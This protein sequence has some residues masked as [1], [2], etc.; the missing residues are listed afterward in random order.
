MTHPR[1]PLALVFAL[2]LNLLPPAAPAAVRAARA[3]RPSQAQ[4]HSVRRL[5]LPANDIV[6][7]QQ[8]G[9]IYASVPSRAGAGGNSITTVNPATGE[10]GTPVYVGSE[11]RKLALSADGSVMYVEVEGAGVVR[12]FDVPTQTPGA[13]FRLGFEP[14]SLYRTSLVM[15]MGVVPGSP[16]TLVVL[17]RDPGS[18]AN[19]AGAAVYDNGVIR[20]VTVPRV[21]NGSWLA[22]SDTPGKLY[23]SGSEMKTLTFDASGIKIAG[24]GPFNVTGQIALAGG[25]VYSAGGQVIDPE[26]KTI[27][28]TF[29]GV[30]YSAPFALDT[31][32]GRAYYL[33]GP[34]F[35]GAYDQRTLKAYDLNTRALVGELT[36]TGV[37]GT[38]ARV[39]RWGANGLAFASG[40]DLYLIQTTLI[41]SSEPVPDPTPTPEPTPTPTPTPFDFSVRQVPLAN[42]DIAYNPAS[43]TFFASVPSSAGAAGNSVT[44][45]DPLTL[46]VGTPVYV[47][48]EP[49]PLAF[50]A[51][52]QTLYVGL[53]G[54]G[55][56]RRFDVPTGT[57]GA[58]FTLG[59][60]DEGPYVADAIAVVGNTNRVAVARRA[61]SYASSV[62]LFDG[63]VML[64]N[65]VGFRGIDLKFSDPAN[66]YMA[67]DGGAYRLTA[68]ATGLSAYNWLADAR[69]G[70]IELKNGLLYSSRGSAVDASTGYLRGTFS[71]FNFF[72][73]E[74]PGVAVDAEHGRVFFLTRA[75][76]PP[77]LLAY[78][79]NTFLPLGSITLTGLPFTE[80]G[81]L[82]RWGANGLAWR[83]SGGVVLLQ[84]SLV[85]GGAAPVP[86]P[87]PT[88]TPAA[89]PTPTPQAPT[90]FRP[91]GLPA[92]DLVIHGPTQTLYLSVPGAAGPASGNSL[93]PVNPATG[94]AGTPVPVGKEPDR[95]AISDNG[96]FIYARLKGDAA[97]RRFDVATQ[98]AGLQF[99]VPNGAFPNFPDMEVLPGNPHSLAY[100][101]SK[102]TVYDDGVARPNTTDFRADVDFIE[103]SDTASKL[104]GQS[105]GSSVI[106]FYRLSVDGSGVKLLGEAGHLLWGDM[107]YH[108]GLLY[109]G[110]GRVYE[111]D[112]M[113]LV[114]TF[115]ASGAV[116]VDPALG[117]V[118]YVSHLYASS[119]VA[120][121]AF[122]LNTF[123]PL[124][125]AALPVGGDVR[126]AVR[127]G[128]NG[129][130]I[131]VGDESLAYP[132]G[133]LYL[134]Q[135][136]L[137]SAAAPVPTGVQF[138]AASYG[139]GESSGSA[140][141]GVIRTG[142]LSGTTTVD[143]ATGDGTANSRTNYTTARGT[144][145]FAPGE[146]S[147]A[148]TVLITQ[149][150]LA[151]GN[152]SLNLT[153]GNARGAEVTGGASTL[154]I[155]DDDFVN[156]TVN[157]ND[158]STYFV[159]QHYHDF[160]NRPPDTSG[161]NFWVGD[162]EKCQGDAQCR[163]VKRINVSA[164]FFLSIEF[165]ETGY[166]VYRMYK[167][168][169]GDINP[170]A[171]PVPV[172]LGEFLAD[173][174]SVREGVR[175][176]IGNWQQQ[177]AANQ[178][179]YADAFV[180]RE[181][182]ASAFPAGMTPAA[183][184][185]KLNQNA[186]GALS[187]EER[188]QLV[189]QLSSGALTRAQVLRAVADD[190]TL[191]DAE[192][193][194]A[195]VLMQY[196]G[197]LRRDPDTGPDS[198]Y[199]GYNF[200]LG[201]LNE[202]NGNYVAAEMVKAFL[203]STEYRRRF[204]N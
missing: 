156:S 9:L 195:F 11:P 10:T 178:A 23:A 56:V 143:Y 167:A 170:P 34:P 45:L 58:Q 126:A 4:T 152:K 153:L 52:G 77:Q 99:T 135:S 85:D 200:W 125:T 1:A 94:Q 72:S 121:H 82:W 165:Q 50:S 140:T 134:I 16:D 117:R 76:G 88:P 37:S 60:S 53:D 21:D 12:R 25:R 24:Y 201:K 188:D 127:W 39:V 181:R 42:N 40:D 128:A 17:R 129:L 144:L 155:Q 164:A 65:S 74:V 13:E 44:T 19:T 124:G 5:R 18:N 87:T 182:F 150:G 22:F 151:E 101:N 147:K 68:D 38:A 98:T 79:L 148:F 27:L 8:T 161:L 108:G 96:E 196:F 159:R 107:E 177:L 111:P 97:V 175:V 31:Q 197:Y 116:L 54:A 157:V 103:F 109:T 105:S 123:L 106:D 80:R 71:I 183:F 30:G 62:S 162:I 49:R 112:S 69:G 184:V 149:N 138:G 166:Y 91:T 187:S 168:A 3:P 130:A 48:S 199:A 92:N 70:Y 83:W 66:L 46:A 51:D 15:D 173:A 133:R 179:A 113:R 89:T 120:V 174:Q 61:G 93:M 63:G 158:V 114:G 203:E 160:L 75:A 154:T 90:F 118:F 73:Y 136:S 172:R 146:S 119:Q 137:I 26:A 81:R 189:A 86:T 43:Q 122:D 142:D 102:V 204:G 78:D 59:N 28:G 32:A 198:D 145:T 139:T 141:V 110:S 132:S 55:A 202:F 190:Q 67:T 7:N 191:K 171:V 95:L 6:F 64:P 35:G 100:A 41:P 194:R 47:G 169:Y 57:P 29:P 33:T 115:P 185:D 36:L 186:G 20:P 104:Y 14:G 193:R 163:Q 192:V 84:T 131:L 176:G 180:G 2:L